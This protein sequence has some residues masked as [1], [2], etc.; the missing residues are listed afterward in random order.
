MTDQA[1]ESMK[2]NGRK[3]VF[4]ADDNF[5]V[6]EAVKAQIDSTP[7]LRWIGCAHNADEMLAHA[8]RI[9]ADKG[10]PDIVLLDIDMPGSDPF[11]AIGQLQRICPDVRVLMHSASVRR[12]WIDRAVEA[13]AWGYVAKN[14]GEQA[15]LKAMRA[16]LG[17]EF[18]VT[19]EVKSVMG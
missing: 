7:D 16:V 13:G 10:C 8:A 15:L 14:D 19:H 9:A 2:T 11:E 17:G 18:A 12:D 5:L 1:Q 4:C 6:T 3:K